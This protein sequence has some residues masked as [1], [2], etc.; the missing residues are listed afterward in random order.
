MEFL[1]GSSREVPFNT[2]D[3]MKRERR[4]WLG[5]RTDVAAAVM[6]CEEHLHLLPPIPFSSG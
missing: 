1:H 6:T 2:S 5:E 4:E 3:S